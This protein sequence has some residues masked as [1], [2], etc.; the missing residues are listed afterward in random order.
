MQTPVLIFNHNDKTVTTSKPG[1]QLDE[2]LAAQRAQ[3]ATSGRP[4]K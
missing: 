1:R 2:L 4:K 3:V